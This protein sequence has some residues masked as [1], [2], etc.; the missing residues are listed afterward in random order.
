M[1]VALVCFVEHVLCHQD[2]SLILRVLIINPKLPLLTQKTK[3]R[4]YKTNSG[5]SINTRFNRKMM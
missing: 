1:D 2:K 3:Q 4:S 5:K